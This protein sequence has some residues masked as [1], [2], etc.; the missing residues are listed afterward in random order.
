MTKTELFFQIKPSVYYEEKDP[1]LFFW[2]I[3]YNILIFV[4]TLK[5]FI[6]VQEKLNLPY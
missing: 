6:I 1:F 4:Q 3:F 5:F 2:N